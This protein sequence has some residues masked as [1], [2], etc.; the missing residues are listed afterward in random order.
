MN[1]YNMW[2]TFREGHPSFPS[3][4]RIDQP[5]LWGEMIKSE[6]PFLSVAELSEL[7]RDKEISPVEATMACL[8]CIDSLDFKF[9]AY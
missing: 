1:P 4:L 7:I 2:A 8:D 5:R 6:I 9:N 3:H